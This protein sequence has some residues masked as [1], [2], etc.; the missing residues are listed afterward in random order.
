MINAFRNF[1]RNEKASVTVEVVLVSLILLWGYFGMFILFD[2]YRALSA[3]IRASY[4]LSDL[5]SRETQSIDAAYIEGLN[6]IQDVITQSY[7]R[8]V[9]RISVVSYDSGS[10][11]HDLEWSDSTAGQ[12]PVTQGNLDTSLVPHLPMMANGEHL[13]AVET[14]VAYN[15][16]LNIT[17]LPFYGGNAPERTA[18]PDN[19]EVFPAL[20]FEAI[21]I[22]RPRFAGQ[23]CWVTCT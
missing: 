3:N 11:S 7:E 4:T 10:S 14:W 20:Y 2:A 22:T 21:A 13:I 12:L 15:P 1:P 18:N 9:L 8:T 6:E 16:F 5:I 19:F 23:L 17:L